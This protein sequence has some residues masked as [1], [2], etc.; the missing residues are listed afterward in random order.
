MGVGGREDSSKC[1]GFSSVL[2]AVIGLRLPARVAVVCPSQTG[3]F[4]LYL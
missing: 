3:P 4:M 2:G 1:P